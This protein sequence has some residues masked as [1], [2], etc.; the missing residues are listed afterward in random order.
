[1]RRQVFERDNI[2]KRIFRDGW[3]EFKEAHPRFVEVDG[4]VKKM[5]G[6]GNSEN[7]YASYVCEECSD[8]KAWLFFWSIYL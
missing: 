2:L 3:E 4:V 6:C 8:K 1:M 7:G 5:L